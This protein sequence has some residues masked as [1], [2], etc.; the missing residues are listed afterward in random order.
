M[1]SDLLQVGDAEEELQDSA[2]EQR[3][4]FLI[5]RRLRKYAGPRLA[6]EQIQDG[7]KH[8][9]FVG[10]DGVAAEFRPVGEESPP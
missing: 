6:V 2:M 8:R 4:R 7:F 1:R 9:K 5:R 3:L 10:A